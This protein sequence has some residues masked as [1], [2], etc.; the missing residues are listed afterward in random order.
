MSIPTSNNIG[1]LIE[2]DMPEFKDWLMGKFIEWEKTQPRRQSY[3][4]FARYLNVKQSSLSQWMAGSYDPEDENIEKIAE[5][6]GE[7]TYDA[8]GLPRPDRQLE[9]LVNIYDGVPEENH[10]VLISLVE[11][12]AKKLGFGTKR[13]R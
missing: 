12:I 11:E 13:K 10:E 2:Y 9:K 8:L 4:A 5:K 3:S 1:D 7:E 6:L